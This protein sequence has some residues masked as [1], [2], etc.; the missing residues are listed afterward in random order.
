[1]D[2]WVNSVN[3]AYAVGSSGTILRYS[4]TDSVPFDLQFDVTA[5]KVDTLRSK[6]YFTDKDAQ[7]LYVVN[8]ATGFTEKYFEFD[9]M[10][11][12]MTMSPDGSKLYVALLVQEHSS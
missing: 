1:M 5:T 4:D 7:R 11:E 9:Y 10:P 6:V 8:L 3:L 2:V 12:R